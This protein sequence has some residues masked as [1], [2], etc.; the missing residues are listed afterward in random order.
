MGHTLV[1]PGMKSMLT[2]LLRTQQRANALARE[3]LQMDRE[4]FNYEKRIVDE[5]M[6]LIPFLK[7]ISTQLIQQQQQQRH[8]P[9][10][11]SAAHQ[12]SSAVH[13]NGHQDAGEEEEDDEDDPV[14][15][16]AED[17]GL[18]IKDESNT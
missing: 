6:G 8:E 12:A 2:S 14:V 5:V 11:Q 15:V 4:K 18:E 16:L 10:D 9:R 1:V 17:E 13:C 7:D 3:R